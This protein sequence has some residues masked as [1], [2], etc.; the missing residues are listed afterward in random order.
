MREQSDDAPL[1]QRFLRMGEKL[2]EVLTQI[3]HFDK[4][5][6]DLRKARDLIDGRIMEFEW[7]KSKVIQDTWKPAVNQLE[8]LFQDPLL[9]QNDREMTE[10]DSDG[11][12]SEAETVIL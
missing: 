12:I 8:D 2:N 3:N 7:Q 5:I 10:K 6:E 1:R 11:G 9:T 4:R